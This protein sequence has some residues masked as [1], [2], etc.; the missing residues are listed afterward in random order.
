LLRTYETCKFDKTPTS[1]VV[2]L[3]GPLFS[4]ALSPI[5]NFLQK[6]TSTYSCANQK[7][8]L[9]IFF[10]GYKFLP[11]FPGYKQWISW[12]SVKERLRIAIHQCAEEWEGFKRERSSI[13][14]SFNC[15][16][17]LTARLDGLVADL[18]S[19]L[20]KMEVKVQRALESDAKRMF[21]FPLGTVPLLTIT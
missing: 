12:E 2:Q 20:V 11:K 5:Y 3:C 10:R 19:Q 13:T 14:E 18:Q 17:R 16:D 15:L 6:R 4:V 9:G 7:A 21:I 8:T 1:Y